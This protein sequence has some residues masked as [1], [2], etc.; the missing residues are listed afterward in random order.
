MPIESFVKLNKCRS[1]VHCINV[2]LENK[3]IPKWLWNILYRKITRKFEE[4]E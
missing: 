4:E 3:I 1:C 2:L